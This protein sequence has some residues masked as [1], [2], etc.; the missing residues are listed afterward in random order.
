ML[1]TELKMGGGEGHG[2]RRKWSIRRGMMGVR[3]V[4]DV[5]ALEGKGVRVYGGRERRGSGF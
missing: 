1:R 3:E 4:V 2:L 5:D